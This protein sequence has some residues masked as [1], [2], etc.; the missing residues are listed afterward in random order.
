MPQQYPYSTGHGTILK[1]NLGEDISLNPGF[2][3]GTTG[4]YQ[5]GLELSVTN[6]TQLT[7]PSVTLHVVACYD[8]LAVTDENTVTVLHQ[9]SFT[10]GQVST[11]PIDI[12]TKFKINRTIY[13]GSFWDSIKSAFNKAKDFLQG[14]KI[15]S[16]VA[17]QLGPQGQQVGKFAQQFGLGCGNCGGCVECCGPQRSYRPGRRAGGMVME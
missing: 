13:G 15:I 4:K 17:N 11:V 5:L 9:A 1:L 8:G 3:V 2:C 12:H 7:L 6:T 14:T 10:P 16:T